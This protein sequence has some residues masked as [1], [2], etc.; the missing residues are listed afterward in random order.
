MNFSFGIETLLT[1][2]TREHHDWGG[3]TRL[4]MNDYSTH[5]LDSDKGLHVSKLDYIMRNA[6]W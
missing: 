6:R 3:I 4:G 2:T 5:E 1:N